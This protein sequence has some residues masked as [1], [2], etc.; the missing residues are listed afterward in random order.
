MIKLELKEDQLEVVLQALSQQPF[1]AVASLI[2]N[3]LGQARAQAQP[4]Q[5]PKPEEKK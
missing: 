2:E 4:V 5:Q 3:I 1:R